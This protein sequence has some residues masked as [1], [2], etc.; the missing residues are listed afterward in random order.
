M[1]TTLFKALVRS[2]LEY[3][4]SIWNPHYDCHIQRIERIQKRFLYLLTSFMGKRNELMHYT[5]RLKFFKLKN[6]ADRR[7]VADLTFL[8]KLLNGHIQIP[9]ILAL[10]KFNIPRPSYRCRNYRFLYIKRHRTEMG[11]H[12]PLTRMSRLC[13]Q[14]WLD[15]GIDIFEK[16]LIVFKKRVVESLESRDSS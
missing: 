14:L 4:P 2:H 13:N 8:Y 3:C 7:R 6:L 9:D 15:C 10:V 5:D 16:S 11:K 12:S 1:K